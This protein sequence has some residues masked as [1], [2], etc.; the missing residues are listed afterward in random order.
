MSSL[1]Y[2]IGIQQHPA[3][4]AFLKTIVKKPLQNVLG[5][6]TSF[7]TRRGYDMDF[8]SCQ[9][10]KPK[11]LRWRVGVVARNDKEAIISKAG[12]VF[13]SCGDR[14]W[15]PIEQAHDV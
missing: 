3:L 7:V 5:H 1:G 6:R 4:T 8:D 15:L 13:V 9:P 2:V 14:S 12:E 11:V 10:E